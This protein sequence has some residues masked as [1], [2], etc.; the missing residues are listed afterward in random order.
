[1]AAVTP[2]L[3]AGSTVIFETT[4]PVGDTRERYGTRLAEATG[5]TMEQITRA[6]ICACDG[7]NDRIATAIDTRRALGLLQG[8]SDE[9]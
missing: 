1:M 3:H 5:L 6:S 2:G 4:L 9:T 7:I 8:L